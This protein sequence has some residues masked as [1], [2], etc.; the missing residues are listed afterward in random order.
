MKTIFELLDGAGYPYFRHGTVPASTPADFFTFENI[1][2][3]GNLYA[4]NQA[5]LYAE[6]FAVCW[7]TDDPAKI[8]SPLND[9]VKAARADGWI[10]SEWPRDIGSG[11]PRLFGRYTRL[12]RVGYTEGA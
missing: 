8:Y 12:T 7:Y 3:Y 6:V 10:I 2:T 1:D 5:N 9:L 4:D 11:E